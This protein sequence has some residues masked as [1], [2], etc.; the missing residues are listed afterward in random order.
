MNLHNV[1]DY[2]NKVILCSTNEGCRQM[3][4]VIL[5]NRLEGEIRHYFSTDTIECDDPEDAADF[6]IDF[7]HS[8][9]PTGLPLHDLALKVGAVV[10]L[11]RNLDAKRGLSRLLNATEHDDDII[12]PRIPLTTT[13]DDGLPFKL[14]RLQF[15]VR[16]AFS[17]TINKSLGQT[18]DR[19]GIYLPSPVFSHGQLYVAFSRVRN[20]ESVK[21]YIP[22]DADGV[23]KNVVFREVL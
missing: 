11:L 6:P 15:P 12:I 5:R 10:M 1:N 21:V 8:L 19:V 4:E 16:L 3:N 14:R 23:T 17:V 2:A 18:F 7:I 22:T 20:A 9:H 13:E